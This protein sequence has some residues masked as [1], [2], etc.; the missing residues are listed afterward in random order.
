ML[1]NRRLKTIARTLKTRHFQTRIQPAVFKLKRIVVP[2]DQF[3]NFLQIL[4]EKRWIFHKPCVG[5]RN[6]VKVF[7]N[8]LWK[9]DSIQKKVNFS[10]FSSAKG[11]SFHLFNLLYFSL[12]LL[13]Q[14]SSSKFRAWVLRFLI[15]EIRKASFINATWP[16]MA[17][18]SLIL[19]F[20]ERVFA[21]RWSWISLMNLTAFCPMN[22][23]G[24]NKKLRTA[25]DS[26]TKTN[27]SAW[28]SFIHL[29]HLLL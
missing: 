10:L 6:S 17:L 24:V 21:L 29:F 13:I 2:V 27:F 3:V 8:L 4:D 22:E 9:T 19:G 1:F 23:Q 25:L 28:L 15:L 11:Y 12:K 7:R 16:I 5:C 14:H 18:S 20:S 26:S